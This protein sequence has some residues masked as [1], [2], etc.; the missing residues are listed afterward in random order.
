[1]IKLKGLNSKELYLNEDNI[2]KIEEVPETLITLSN[3]KKYI[4]LETTKDVIDKI[5]EFK[6]KIFTVDL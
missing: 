6:R 3:G 4:V 1:M 5:I 2:E